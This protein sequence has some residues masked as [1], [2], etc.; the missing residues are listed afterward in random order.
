MERILNKYIT[1]KLENNKTNIYVD[2]ELFNQCKYILLNLN[3]N[4]LDRYDN[5]DSIDSVIKE[6]SREHETNKS[7]LSPNTEFFGHCSNIE[8]WII[9]GYNL[10]IL[11]SSLSIPLLR[12]LAILKDPMAI[13]KLKEEIALRL[14]SGNKKV[15][16]YFLN[17]DYLWFFELEELEVIFQ[18]I[19]FDD[20]DLLKQ[21]NS[22][23]NKKYII[24]K[25]KKRGHMKIK[26]EERK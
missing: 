4:N 1:L 26:L 12:R 24:N 6:Y 17:E 14:E 10:N 7:R 16:T 9:N 23:I 5:I 21:V 15:F 3:I 13:I 25:Y 11:H 18:K 8:A 22:L 19:S 20:Q 2:G